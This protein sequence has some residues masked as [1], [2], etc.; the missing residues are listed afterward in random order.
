M[1]GR[2]CCVCDGAITGRA[3]VIIRDS[4]SGARPNDWAHYP[5][6]PECGSGPLRRSVLARHLPRRP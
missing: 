5:G 4:M 1:A 6:D 3:K 2:I